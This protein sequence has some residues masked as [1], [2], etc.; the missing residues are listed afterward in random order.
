MILTIVMFSFIF[1]GAGAWVAHPVLSEMSERRAAKRSGPRK[2]LSAAS[3][4]IM[5]HWDELPKDSRPDEDIL[6]ML[7]ALD[8]KY[9]VN[10]V[11]NHFR[12]SDVGDYSYERNGHLYPS[13]FQDYV[14]S[15]K[16]HDGCKHQTACKFPEY[17]PLA[18][19]IHQV[20]EAAKAQARALQVAGVQ[21][22]IDAVA[23]LTDRMR[24][25]R[26]IIESVTKELT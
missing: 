6:S 26:E 5:K 3:R 24:S 25:E 22:N 17:K 23:R 8:I 21:H 20:N 10:E 1:I 16:S 19:S 13:L 11:N 12:I 15:W 2:G 9:G 7:K 4:S 18:T 14:F